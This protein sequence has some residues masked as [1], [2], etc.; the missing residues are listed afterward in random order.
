MRWTLSHRADRRAL[1]LA[2]RHYN[3]QRPGTSQFVPPG[4]CIVL[5][6]ANADALWDSSWPLAQ[7]TKHRWAG[8]WICS[9]FRNESRNLSSELIREAVA[10]TKYIWGLPPSLGMVTFID[11][12]KVRRKRDYRRCY[13]RA[14]WKPCGRTK[15]GLLVLQLSSEA[16]PI[17]RP[18]KGIQLSLLNWQP[19]RRY[20]ILLK[21]LTLFGIQSNSFSTASSKTSKTSE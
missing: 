21:D 11:P 19:S 15:G 4:R 5:L 12:A 18:P 14:G 6:T 17:A 2:D 16:M 1:P 13:K 3:R 10:A 8:A 20:N 7:Y 9:S